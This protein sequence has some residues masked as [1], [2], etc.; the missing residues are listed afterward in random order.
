MIKR[1]ILGTNIAGQ[2][3]TLNGESYGSDQFAGGAAFRF[4]TSLA[5]LQAERWAGSQ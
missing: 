1:E 4:G 3:L 5:D 2:N